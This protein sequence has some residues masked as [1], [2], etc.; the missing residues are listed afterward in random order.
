MMVPQQFKPLTGLMT[1]TEKET[2]K[3]DTSMLERESSST[4][5]RR[6]EDSESSEAFWM[7]R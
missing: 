6:D 5:H 4:L 1:P 2:L 7:F 3:A